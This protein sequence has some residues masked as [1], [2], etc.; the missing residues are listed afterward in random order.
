MKS[1]IH[2]WWGLVALSMIVTSVTPPESWAQDVGDDEAVRAVIA[3]SIDAFNKH[4]A[5]EWAE[6]CTPDARLVTVRGEVMNGVAEIQNG[7][8][9][10]FESRGRGAT[11]TTRDVQVRFVRPDVALAYVTNE[12]TGVTDSAGQTQPPHQE[13]S[14]RVLVEEHGTWRIAAFHNT[15]LQP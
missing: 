12:M 3:A 1:P 14:L 13:L 11:L 5:R 10:V 2:R 8:R 15:R 7:L 9:N 4:D 6:L